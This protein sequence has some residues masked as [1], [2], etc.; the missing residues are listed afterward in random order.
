[1]SAIT[2]TKNI[3]WFWKWFKD[4]FDPRLLR[5]ILFSYKYA[6]HEI[7]STP[8]KTQ[9]EH[10]ISFIKKF[11]VLLFDNLDDFVKKSISFYKKIVLI[12]YIPEVNVHLKMVFLLKFITID[13]ISTIQNWDIDWLKW[14]WDEN[15]INL[16]DSIFHNRIHI[17]WHVG[18]I[19]ICIYLFSF[20]KIE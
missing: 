14:V 6:S 16:N 12:K 10:V 18:Y 17:M 8:L 4:A 13:A 11:F 5:N 3:F 20:D 2:T 15:I 7:F 1:M 19:H 9:N